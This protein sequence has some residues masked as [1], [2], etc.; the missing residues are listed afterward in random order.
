MFHS[1]NTVSSSYSALA[2]YQIANFPCEEFQ[3]LKQTKVHFHTTSL[4]ASYF[5]ASSNPTVNLI[6]IRAA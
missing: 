1:Y 3:Q 4:F 6:S 2:K 5:T